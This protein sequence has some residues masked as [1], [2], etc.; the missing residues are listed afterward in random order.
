MDEANERCHGLVEP[1]SSVGRSTEII[2]HPRR[3]VKGFILDYLV[4][5]QLMVGQDVAGS[6]TA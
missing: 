3:M 1:S 4:F 2:R 6:H 5:T